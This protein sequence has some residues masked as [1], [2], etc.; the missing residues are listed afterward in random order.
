MDNIKQNFVMAVL[1]KHFLIQLTFTEIKKINNIVAKRRS[2]RKID[3][4]FDFSPAAL[5]SWGF[6]KKECYVKHITELF[7]YQRT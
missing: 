6:E 7:L 5:C 3:S 4:N 2:R 1:K